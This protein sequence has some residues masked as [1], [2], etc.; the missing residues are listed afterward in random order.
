[1]TRFE[2]DKML[3]LATAAPSRRAARASWYEV[4]AEASRASIYLYDSIGEFGVTARDFVGELRALDVDTIELRIN[5]GGGSI[6]DG[7]AIYQALKDHR[8][9]VEVVVDSLAASA[10]S[11]I[12]QAGDR[13]VMQRNA[14]MMIHDGSGMCWGSAKD[15]RQMAD[16]LDQLSNNIA[17]VYQQRAGGTV[18]EWRDRMLAETWFTAAQAVEVGLADEVRDSSAD[19]AA[20]QPVA[21]AA[22]P[23]P[24]AAPLV[25]PQELRTALREAF[26][27]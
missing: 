24:P 16:L 27:A 21:A 25:D 26:A 20:R 19:N 4:R 10:A 3:A 1:M 9:R 5:S 15:M 6:F 11:F 22:A 14:T 8:A 7:V 23:E 13:V 18:E 17:D 2:I 12:A